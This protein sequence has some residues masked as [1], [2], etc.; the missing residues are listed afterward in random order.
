MAS[1]YVT[2]PQDRIY[3][4]F[5]H[6][7]IVQLVS[8]GVQKIAFPWI[9]LLSGNATHIIF[10]TGTVS[11]SQTLKASI[12]AWNSGSPPTTILGATNNGFGT[13]ASPAA[14]TTYTVALGENVAVTAG[15]KYW[16]V[17]EYDST[18]G[19]LQIVRHNASG[20]ALL[21]TFGGT[22]ANGDPLTLY[23]THNGTSWGNSTAANPLA[24]GVVMDV[25]WWNPSNV[26]PPSS[27]PT[28][29]SSFHSGSTPDEYGNRMNLPACTAYGI[30]VYSDLDGAA[31]ICLY[32]DSGT[33]LAS[34][35]SVAADRK[36]TSNSHYKFYFS[37]PVALSAGWHRITLKPTTTTNVTRYISPHVSMSGGRSMGSDCYLTSRTDSGAFTDTTDS[38]M[39]IWLI[40]RTTDSGGGGGPSNYNPYRS[41][42][43]G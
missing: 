10:R 8:G 23:G 6:E 15:V 35:S 11:T 5:G 28:T 4:E 21:G 1:P 16:V 17:I 38:L 3:A 26:L 43:F 9:P 14:A 20:P 18:L 41:R 22:P 7:A 33:V 27:T 40:A 39:A 13:Q 36:V 2:F 32:D 34:A 30:E 19:N 12:R 31:D 29:N 24:F 42:T 25:D 37:S